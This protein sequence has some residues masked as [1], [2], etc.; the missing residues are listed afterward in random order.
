M[1]EF[2]TLKA[3]GFKG[4]AHRI[5]DLDL[6]R[7]GHML[8]VGEDE[9]H[10]VI[11]VESAGG[12]FDKQGRP[13][14][15]FEPHVFYRN[16]SGTKRALAVAKG[17]AYPAWKRDYPDDSYPRFL[18][19]LEIDEEAAIKACSW[20]LGQILGENHVAAG[21]DTPQ[22]MVVAFAEDEDEHLEAMANFILANRL[23]DELRS[24]NWAAFARGYNGPRYAENDYHT[25]L[26]A[27]FKWWQGKPDTPWAPDIPVKPPVKPPEKPTEPDLPPPGVI[28]YPKRDGPVWVAYVLL[29]EYFG[30]PEP[31]KEAKM[32]GGALAGIVISRVGK[33][34]A[35]VVIDAVQ[36]AALKDNPLAPKDA[37]IVAVDAAREAMKD[38]RLKEV[39]AYAEHNTN[40]EPNS[41]S[42]VI[43]GLSVT[44]LAS[45]IP[46]VVEFAKSMG[47]DTPLETE[48]VI[49]GLTFL[50]QIGG[51]AWAWYGRTSARKPIGE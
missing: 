43:Q 23:D 17:L 29:A 48:Q 3:N 15:L 27:A 13:K 34:V 51:V 21:Y 26:A 41:K 32:V 36:N 4:A 5:D 50:A 42:R 7:I 25:K 28:P 24:H 8:G 47:F 9:I 49:T 16:L 22:E 20:G 1:M 11:D 44:G 31:S 39:I 40:N 12:G 2:R 30:D 19:A 33:V 6:P 37:P 35:D 38:P 18:Q 14:I 45:L 10:A 46:P